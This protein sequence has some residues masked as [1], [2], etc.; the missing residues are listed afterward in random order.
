[1]KRSFFKRKTYKRA[2]TAKK[3]ARKRVKLIT[4]GKLQRTCD[5]LIQ[6]IGRLK[7]R[8]S[9]VSGQPSE[10]IHHICPKSVSN[11][12]RYDWDNLVALTNGE[13]MRHHQANDP[14]IHGTILFKRGQEW[15]DR[16]IKRRY[17]ESI[18]TDR[19]YYEEVRARLEKELSM[20]E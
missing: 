4:I 8:Y 14:L 12:L 16:L 10:V 19:A 20:L 5:A 3:V 13:H 2:V 17:R 6:Q 9:E 1:M 11:A 18:K 7:W 15:W